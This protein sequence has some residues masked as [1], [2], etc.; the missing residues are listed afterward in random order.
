MDA[1]L[2]E[3]NVMRGRVV[4]DKERPLENWHVCLLEGGDSPADYHAR[5]MSLVTRFVMTRSDGSFECGGV[6]AFDFALAVRGSRFGSEDGP[7]VLLA[8]LAAPT[9]NLMLRIPCTAL[10]SW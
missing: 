5:D 9:P 8:D 6:P 1:A 7:A 3:L 2:E 4:D 10:T